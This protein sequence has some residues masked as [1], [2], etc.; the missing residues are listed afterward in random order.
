MQTHVHN[1]RCDAIVLEAARFSRQEK[2]KRESLRISR[3]WNIISALTRESF[4]IVVARNNW[5]LMYFLTVPSNVTVKYTS[6][7]LLTNRLGLDSQTPFHILFRQ[8]ARL[9]LLGTRCRR[10]EIFSRITDQCER[11]LFEVERVISD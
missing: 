2:K 8:N 7:V 1:V 6:R 4:A 10:A 3:E 5:P 11:T 9:K